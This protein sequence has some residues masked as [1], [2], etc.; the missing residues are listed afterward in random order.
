MNIPFVDLSRLTKK[1]ENEFFSAAKEVIN[2]SAFI[3][4]PEVKSF[5][6]EFAQY[7]SSKHC[8]SVA[9]GTDALH[10]SCR[11][12]EIGSGDE[13]IIPANTFIATALGVTLSGATPVLVDCRELDYCI[14]PNL[15]ES[16]I[17]PKTKAIIPV[18]LYGQCVD[19]DAI[20]KI[21]KKYSLKIIED[22]SQAHGAKYKGKYAGCFGDLACFSFYPGKNLGAFGDGGCVTTNNSELAQNLL[23][24][25]NYGSTQKYVHKTLGFNSRLDTLQA[26]VL[27]LKLKY[28]NECNESRRWVASQ[29]QNFLKEMDDLILPNSLE[30]RVHVYHLY[31]VRHVKRNDL[32]AFLKEKRISAL[33][34]YPIPIHLQEAYLSMGYNQGSFPVAEKTSREI[35]S[36]PIFPYMQLEEIS[37]VAKVMKEFLKNISVYPYSN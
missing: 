8:I 19:M 20:C 31:V 5:E 36:L 37:Y 29:Y 33:I 22:A 17:T 18:H 32:I 14:D 6:E 10:L 16:A 35:F 23:H 34:H 30:D 4:G 21:A 1:I 13:V 12:L 24:L 28:L 9:S 3:L 11:A 27:R 2:R 7:L 26:C 15:I 25:R